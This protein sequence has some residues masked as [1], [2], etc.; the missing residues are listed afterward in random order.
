M[1]AAVTPMPKKETA[2][3]HPARFFYATTPV[4]RDLQQKTESRTV[5][6]GN[7]SLLNVPNVLFPDRTPSPKN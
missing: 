3:A 5:C 2:P 4:M 1:I 7:Y 6:F